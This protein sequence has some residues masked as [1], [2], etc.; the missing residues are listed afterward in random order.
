LRVPS[1]IFRGI[2][3]VRGHVF[4]DDASAINDAGKAVAGPQS[5]D[6]R[7]IGENGG[8]DDSGENCER[9]IGDALVLQHCAKNLRKL[10]LGKVYSEMRIG[11]MELT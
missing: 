3:S 9:I 10:W 11:A 6:R 2:R 8:S 1:Q 5:E 4:R 7:S